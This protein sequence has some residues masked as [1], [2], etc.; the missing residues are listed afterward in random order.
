MFHTSYD[1]RLL[2]ISGVLFFLIYEMRRKD[3]LIL[4][5]PVNSGEK[6]KQFSI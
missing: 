2:V 6:N 3:S 4:K 1:T 5:D